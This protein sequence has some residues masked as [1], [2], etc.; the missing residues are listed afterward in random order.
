MVYTVCVGVGEGESVCVFVCE[1][2]CACVWATSVP[3]YKTEYAAGL[4]QV[5]KVAAQA[6]ARVTILGTTPA[7]NTA[8]AADDVTVVALNK[9]AAALASHL[10][11]PFVDLH[12]P[13][14]Q[15]CGP[16]SRAFSSW[17]RSM[18]SSLIRFQ[19]LILTEISF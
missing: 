5:M 7:H 2:A 19:D 16:V 9:A 6:G 14:I 1:C 8:K 18:I 17:K 10:K 12:T 13:L 3:E 11:L 4:A 15:K